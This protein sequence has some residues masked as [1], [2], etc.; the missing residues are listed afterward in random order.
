MRTEKDT[1]RRAH[2]QRIPYS[3]PEPIAQWF[4]MRAS[5][6]ESHFARSAE[7]D[8]V[9]PSRRDAVN[10]ALI[11]LILCTGVLLLLGILMVFSATSATSIRAIDVHGSDAAV[12]SIAIRHLFYA[13][14]GI[15]LAFG[16]SRIGYQRLE[17][18]SYWL[19]GLGLL[20]QFAVI[21]FG[22]EIAG[23]RNWL[24]FGIIQ[25]QPSEF[26]KLAFIVWMAHILALIPGKAAKD[27]RSFKIAAIGFILTV[28]VI[29]LPGDMGTALIVVMIGAGMAW[30]AGLS[31]KIFSIGIILSSV[32]AGIFVAIAPSR[33]A[34]V[35]SF[36]A[37][38]FALPDIYEPTQSEFAQFAF[39]TGGIFGAGIGASKEKWLSLSEAHTDFIFAIIGEEIGL[40]GALLVVFLFLMMAW[41]F[42]RLTLNNPTRFGQLLTAGAGLW[43]C[44]QAFLNMMVVVGLL[45]VFGVPLPF[46]SQG[47]SAIMANLMM[48]GVVVCAAYAVPG[49]QTNRRI[50]ARLVM[51]SKAVMK[52]TKNG[53]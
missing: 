25:I 16:L 49:V 32:L 44:G 52:S 8:E 4:R 38:L 6:A 34:R 7:M 12:F 31:G 20:L 23:N 53:K 26:L 14:I 10:S 51:A 22:K 42:L 39:G 29:I 36:M 35:T 24:S 5:L 11:S 13:F 17:L 30:L 27:Y 45:P 28:A 40:V 19:F 46:I 15:L 47:G 37:N 43:I 9:Q 50:S 1:P 48:I 18:Y 33:L 2:E 3:Y 41:S 21:L